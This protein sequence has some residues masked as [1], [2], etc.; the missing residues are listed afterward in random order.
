M[1]NSYKYTEKLQLNMLNFISEIPK[2]QPNST[3]TA[4]LKNS[5]FVSKTK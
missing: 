5:S 1:T 4:F 3:K 2:Y